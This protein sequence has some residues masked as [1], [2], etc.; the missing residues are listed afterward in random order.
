MSVSKK[1]DT[2]GRLSANRNEG[3]RSSR[4]ATQ[5]DAA[6]SLEIRRERPRP[7]ELTF[8]EDFM[9]EHSYPSPHNISIEIAGSF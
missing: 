9:L 5:H 6:I 4:R 1:C 7:S 8:A 2:N 3:R